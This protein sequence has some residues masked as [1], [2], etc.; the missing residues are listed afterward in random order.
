MGF[1]GLFVVERVGMSGGLA[2]LWR[3]TGMATLLSYSTNYID[4]SVTLDGEPPWRLTCFYG[5]PERSRRQQSWSLLRDLKAQSSLPWIVIG[6]FNDIASHEEKRGHLPHPDNL[7]RGFNDT[8][9]DCEL[10]DLGMQGHGFTWEKGRGSD[11]WIEEPLDR[12]IAST[13]WSDMYTQAKVLN[14]LAT[15]SDHSALFLEL[16]GRPMRTVGRKFKFE[17]AWL[18]D[19]QCREIVEASWRQSS[20][21]EFQQRINVCG[22][23]LWRW[24][25]EHFRKF[26]RKVQSLRTLLENLR[27]SRAVNDVRRFQATEHE[28]KL[29]LAQEEIYWRQ[30]SKQLWLKEGDLNTKYFHRAAS[31]RKKSNYLQR[32]KNSVGDWVEGSVMHGEILTYFADI[33][34]SSDCSLDFLNSFSARI[35]TDMNERL[36][37]PIEPDEVKGAVFSMAPTR[38]RVRMACLHRSINFFDR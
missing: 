13:D 2:L 25:S 33:F 8:L 20:H 29:F 10:Y 22:Q 19:P 28:L 11:H 18:L 31:H 14:I 4:V 35:T 37:R 30:R 12:A 38:P 9:Q 6:D 32:L 27:S 17:S 34:Q 7:V 16:K 23:D 24:G 26:G 3:E 1:E 36:L 21:Q 15:T 5:F